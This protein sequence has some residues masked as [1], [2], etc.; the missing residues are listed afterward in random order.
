MTKLSFCMKNI[1]FTLFALL[2][3]AACENTSDTAATASNTTD[4]E[5]ATPPPS[6]VDER[7]EAAYQR[8]DTSEAGQIVWQAMEAHGG[9]A[10]WYA[11]GPLYFHFNYQPLDGSTQ[12]NTFQ[13]VNT[14]NATAHHWVASDTTVQ[15][16]WDG[17]Q[18]WIHPDT[19]EIP[20]DTR[21]WS[22]TPYYFIGIPFVLGD[23]GIF[24]EKLEDVEWQ[25]KSHDVVKVTF[26]EGVGDAPDDYYVLYFEKQSHELAVI[27]YI[28][29]YPAYFPDGGHLPEKFMDVQGRQVVDG[30]V[31]PEGY[32]TYW[33]TEEGSGE[34]ITTI[35]VSDVE[36]RP[37]LQA[38][39][40]DT[41]MN[42]KIV[43]EL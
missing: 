26:D 10:K 35:E 6:W 43:E 41:P 19:A 16:G 21:F 11:N 38:S 31:L 15:Y 18:A 39:F 2:I 24:L 27:R 7:V 25:E 22:L 29:S 13:V 42:A 4:V 14:W 36:F 1:L 8:L 28:V 5:T 20:Y 17:E 9:L 37:Q 32:E 33:W 23:D 30:I 40:F 34:R 12:R 3:F